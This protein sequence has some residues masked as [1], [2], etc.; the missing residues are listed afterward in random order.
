MYKFDWENCNEEHISS[1]ELSVPGWRDITIEYIY[2]FSD[3][4]ST[5]DIYWRVKDTEH[6][7]VTTDKELRHAKDAE[8]FFKEFLINFRQELLDWAK[9]IK[10]GL[11]QQ[12]MYEYIEMYKDYI[13]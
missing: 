10:F 3:C 12:W 8:T 7:F 9:V 13:L 4:A 6:T 11:G 1:I 5:K 2:T